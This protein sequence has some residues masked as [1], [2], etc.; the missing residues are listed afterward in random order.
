M[1]MEWKGKEEMGKMR[2]KKVCKIIQR[3][4]RAKKEN[5]ENT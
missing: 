3:R 5:R 4:K 1:K 2:K